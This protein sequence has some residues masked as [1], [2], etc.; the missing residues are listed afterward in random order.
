MNP[1]PARPHTSV[2]ER[3][4]A[5]RV[6]YNL[7]VKQ[8][9][10]IPRTLTTID[11]SRRGLLVVTNDPPPLNHAVRLTLELPNGALPA[12]AS[13]VRY[14]TTPD[15]DKK[16]V[17][18]GLRLF[19]LS[20]ELRARWDQFILSASNYEKVMG[21]RDTASF[22]ALTREGA[23]YAA[24]PQEESH[25]DFD[26]DVVDDLSDDDLRELKAAIDDDD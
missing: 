15:P 16:V 2:R 8:H 19:G 12:M 26:I 9:G 5:R 13:V 21:S 25:D 7:L 23:P 22:R 24:R 3:R 1:L 6:S 14:V 4:T 18:M 10:R 11:V 17:A 20:G